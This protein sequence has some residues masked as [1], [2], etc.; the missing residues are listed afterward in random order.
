M[1]ETETPADL[2][3]PLYLILSFSAGC[4]NFLQLQIFRACQGSLLSSSAFRLVN[5]AVISRVILVSRTVHHLLRL[6]P[7]DRSPSS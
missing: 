6:T 7:Q 4:Q 3:A 5:R 1:E 2:E